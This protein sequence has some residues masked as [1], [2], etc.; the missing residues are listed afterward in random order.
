MQTSNARITLLGSQHQMLVDHLESHP[1][2]HEKAAVV[3]FRRLHIPINGLEKSDRFIAQEIIPF[4]DE[5]VTFSSPTRISFKMEAFT[6]IYRKCEEEGLVFGFVHNHPTGFEAFSAIDDENEGTIFTAIRNRNGNDISFVSMIWAKGKWLARTRY[7]ADPDKAHSVRHILVISDRLH[8][9]GYKESSTEHAEVQARQAAAF[10]KP[11]V[12]MLQS[13]RV[14]VVG[15]GGTGSPFATLIARSG[16]GELVLIDNDKLERSNLNRVRG[17][18][19]KDVNDPK[20]IKLKEFIDNIGVSV[21]VAA[22]KANVDEDP[23]ALDALAS[24]DVIIGCTD[25]FIGREVMNTA[26]YVYAQLLIDIGLGG[27]VCDGLDGQPT[28]RY[29]HGRVSCIMPELGQCLFCQGILQDV[30]VR[31]QYERR[32]NPNLTEEEIKEKYLEDGDTDAPGVGPFTSAIADFAIATLFDLIKPYRW[33]PPEIRRDLF[34]IDFVQ[35]EIRSR[36]TE[37]D[38]ECPYCRKKCFLLLKESNRLNRPILGKRD[39][40]N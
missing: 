6:E 28:L 12:D 5:W 36:T 4:K 29:H 3:L 18:T 22:F 21:K 26:L 34:E 33:F 11:F 9:Y 17:L 1:D 10:G 13:L 7:G 20:A 27:K 8:I 37:G 38:P 31:T 15:T 23:K 24:C 2:G 14:G 30:W 25:D 35:M 19:A 16:I 39:E 40:C 32:K